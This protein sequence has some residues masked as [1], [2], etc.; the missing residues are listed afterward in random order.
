MKKK[1]MLIGAM[2][3]L[4]ITASGLY[5]YRT[6]PLYIGFGAGLSGQWSQLGVQVRNGFLQAVEDVN[7]AGGINGRKVIPYVMD[8]KNDNNHTEAML[9]EMQE[10]NIDYFIGFSVSSMTPSIQ[11]LLDQSDM[12]II[13]PTMSTNLLTGIDD[14]FIRVC[15][16]SSEEAKSLLNVLKEDNLKDFAIVYDTS[17]LAYTEPTKNLVVDSSEVFGL[18]LVYEEGFN[19]KTVDYEALVASI[20]EEKPKQIVIIASGIDT[21]AIAQQL[22]VS[23]NTALLYASAWATTDD[24]L[25]NGGSAI[26]GMRINGLYDISSETD[27]FME[28][29]YKMSSAYGT[30][31]TFP[32]IFGYESLIVLKNAM[33]SSNSFD[34]ETV[35]NEVFRLGS[36][37]GLQQTIEIDE[38]GDAHRGY[39]IYEVHNGRFRTLEN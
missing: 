35:K 10:K 2:V 22:Q 29:R 18:N 30:E 31:P 9:A 3:L 16:A 23:G 13:S 15:N 14:N 1:S 12:L 32:Q 5:Y 21:A 38:F 36:F 39:F 17:N 24:L 25:E 11:T 28:F 26:E 20:L 27:A 7:I 6:R 8:D 19:S 34:V 4:I 33:E 37:E